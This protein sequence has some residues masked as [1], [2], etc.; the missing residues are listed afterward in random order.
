MISTHTALNLKRL[1][2]ENWE[3]QLS[4]EF[5][6]QFSKDNPDANTDLLKNVDKEWLNIIET[7]GGE[8]SWLDFWT[9]VKLCEHEFIEADLSKDYSK[10][11]VY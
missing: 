6:K 8:H 11:L 1:M 7:F 4:V 5:V 10:L 2:V 9:Q 3:D